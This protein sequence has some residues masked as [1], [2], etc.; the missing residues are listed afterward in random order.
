MQDHCRHTVLSWH[1]SLT[2]A[3][4]SVIRLGLPIQSN[5]LLL[6]FKSGLMTELSNKC[7]HIS[8]VCGCVGLADPAALCING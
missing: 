6:L 3:D 4:F 1:L 5:W 8:V 7:Q 2:P